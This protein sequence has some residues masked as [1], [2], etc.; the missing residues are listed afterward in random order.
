MLLPHHISHNGRLVSPD[1]A[2]VSIFNPAI[3][4]AFGVYESIQQRRGVV[5]RLEDHLARL[6]ASAEAI[7]LSLPAALPQIAAWTHAVLAANEC[8]D[9]LIRLFVLGPSSDHAAELFIWPEAPRIPAP[10]IAQQGV[11]AITYAGERALPHA[12]S[13][14]TLVNHLA[15]AAATAAGEH[16]GLL[17]NRAG[18]F[19][20]GASSNLFVVQQGALLTAPEDEVL[21]GVTQIEVLRLAAELG[22]PVAQRPLP[23]AEL[24]RWDEAFLTST[25]RHVLPLVRV[26]GRAIG[27][28]R[29]GPLTQRLQT[30]FEAMFEAALAADFPLAHDA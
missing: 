27:D 9:S 29:P 5:F 26:D 21:A 18:C 23:L 2:A 10:E 17:L 1:R 11:G 8:R 13:L 30:A 14:N 28:G 16:E 19:T 12:K 7:G 3:F 24:A 25:S 22:L 15:K 20:E 6:L 4:G